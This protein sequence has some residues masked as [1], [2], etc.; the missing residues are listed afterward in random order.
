MS[1]LVVSLVV[2]LSA[3]SNGRATMEPISAESTG[4][5]DHYIVYPLSQ[6]IIWFS[7]LLGGHYAL[8]I[9]IVTIIIRAILIPLYRYQ[10]K[11][12][13]KMAEVQ[14]EIQALDEKYSAKD[15]ETQE[16]K[17]AEQERIMD[18][19]GVNPLSGCLPLII[20]TPILLALYQ[21]I[22]R[23]E[24]IAQSS[25][26]WVDLGQHDPYYILP[27]V[28]AGLMY[29]SLRL[30]QASQPNQQAGSNLMSL[31]MPVMI[32]LITFNLPSAL[33]LYFVTTNGFS[34]IQTLLFN[35]PFKIKRER[36]EA[37]EAKRQAERDRQKAIKR[38]K[39]TGRSTKK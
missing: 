34:I 1:L 35:N 5:F 8:G 11:S 15:K 37:E 14:P 4:F 33:S 32:F 39:K 10:T 30:N 31:G 20:Q 27:L 16:K 28:A 9:V 36:E 18:E 6:I 12:T 21:A 3:C 23:T 24:V 7:N 17:A 2:F 25:F 19:A 38:A 22:S 26:L 29:I 13:Q